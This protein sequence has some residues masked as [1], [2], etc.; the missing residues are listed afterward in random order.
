MPKLNWNGEEFK[1][2]QDSSGTSTENIS[3]GGL[4]QRYKHG[5]LT[6]GLLAYYPMD[7]GSGSTLVDKALDNDGTINGA[8]WTS[9]KIGEHAL[10]FDSGEYAA[11][12]GLGSHELEPPFT[13]SAWF[14]SNFNETEARSEL[15]QAKSEKWHVRIED[16]GDGGF[17]SPGN[18]FDPGL[19]LHIQN[20]SD[21]LWYVV[22]FPTPT[23]GW[24]HITA[25]F[26]NQK[27]KVYLDGILQDSYDFGSSI[28]IAGDNLNSSSIGARED[29]T[30]PWNGKIDD[31]RIFERKISEPEIKA[32]YN[33]QRP[34][35]ISPGDTL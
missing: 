7:S 33:L 14:Y 4:Q 8:S 16:R 28:S 32:L 10:S 26:D 21:G 25:T 13:F 29:G 1:D 17:G 35:K 11:I 23:D 31:V 20:N 19:G 5:S 22:S 6:E 24:H 18:S 3:G 34:S 12:D 2:P 15:F 27:M 9:G 30:N